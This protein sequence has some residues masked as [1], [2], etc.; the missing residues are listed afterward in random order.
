MSSAPPAG[1]SEQLAAVVRMHRRRH[2]WGVS[3]AWF[4]ILLALGT[5][6]TASADSDGTPPP[7]WFIDLT[8]GFGVAAAIGLVVAIG[9][10][11]AMRRYP[12]TDRAQAAGL[13]RQRLR[14]AWR[15]GWSGRIYRVLY[16]LA[17]WLG[18]ALFLGA[19]V[20][21]VVWT[22]NGAASLA[23]AGP[24][25]RWATPPINNDGDAATSL[26]VGLLFIFAGA[27]VLRFIY[28][29]VTRV[30]WRRYRQRRAA[31]G[32]VQWPPSG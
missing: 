19:A 12:A 13:E 26:I 17:L 32:A 2:R 21:G 4:L 3:V 7:P 10:S 22:I 14:D 31:D 8:I 23:G 28:R 25:V 9:Y 15:R 29:R 1:D 20:I 16:Q 11:V 30:W 6:A 24:A 18:L 27:L 5:G